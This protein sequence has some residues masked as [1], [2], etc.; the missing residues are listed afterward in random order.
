MNKSSI[1]CGPL[2]ILCVS[3]LAKNL[4]TLLFL[5]FSKTAKLTQRNTKCIHVTCFCYIHVHLLCLSGS[6]IFYLVLCY[7]NLICYISAF[8]WIKLFIID[9]VNSVFFYIF[10]YEFILC[11]Y[12][13]YC[14]KDYAFCT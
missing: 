6:I 5:L 9:F 4:D 14:V 2:Y 8:I 12:C 7:D 1:P 3:F 10:N 11:K 13:V